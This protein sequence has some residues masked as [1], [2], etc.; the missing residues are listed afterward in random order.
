MEE[1]IL[2]TLSDNQNEMF[3]LLN[4]YPNMGYLWNWVT[5]ITLKYS[6]VYHFV[7]FTLHLYLKCLLACCHL[8]YYTWTTPSLFKHD[9]VNFWPLH[10]GVNIFKYLPLSGEKFLWEF[11]FNPHWN[12]KNQKTLS[13]HMIFEINFLKNS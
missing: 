3:C 11:E 10:S 5:F 6:Y 12:M 13:H 4:M 1:I 9:S 7:V 2:K 8:N